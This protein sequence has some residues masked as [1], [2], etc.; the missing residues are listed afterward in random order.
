M[1]NL[2]NLKGAPNVQLLDQKQPPITSE[3]QDGEDICAICMGSYENM[4]HPNECFHKYCFCCLEEWTKIKPECP[5]CLK[6][7]TSIVHSIQ[8]DGTSEKYSLPQPSIFKQIKNNTICWLFILSLLWIFCLHLFLMIDIGKLFVTTRSV[9]ISIALLPL[10]II[11]HIYSLY[12]FQ[13]FVNF[14]ILNFYF[15]VEGPPNLIYIKGL[16]EEI[17]TLFFLILSNVLTFYCIIGTPPNVNE[18]M[19]MF[20][21]E[22]ILCSNILLIIFILFLLERPWKP[23]GWAQQIL[24]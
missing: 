19:L 15:N 21:C 11:A 9:F 24:G 10:F 16:V 14:R 8:T 2:R 4:C 6:K 22:L 3:N 18:I 13:N 17:F 23:A 7:I 20:M 1:E 5:Y 12:I